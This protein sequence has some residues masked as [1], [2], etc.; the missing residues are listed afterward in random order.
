M[1]CDDDALAE[2]EHRLLDGGHALADLYQV[3][4][5]VRTPRGRLKVREIRSVDG[6]AAELI[7]YARPDELRARLSDYTR[8]VIAPPE[9]ARLIAALR[10]TLGMLVMV[11]KRRRVAV[12]GRT[13]V[14]LDRVAGLGAFLEL[15]TVLADGDDETG[16]AG[17]LA[18]VAAMLGISALPPIAGSYSDLLLERTHAGE[19]SDADR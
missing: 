17:E 19:A 14:H 5:Y 11:E 16:A 4:T 18:D 12:V 7:A 9:A 13:R 3:D 15:E 2:I 10:A 1:R 6:E 8:V